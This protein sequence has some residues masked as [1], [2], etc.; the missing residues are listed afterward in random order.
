M[1]LLVVNQLS[2]QTNQETKELQNLKDTILHFDS[3]FWEAYNVCDLEQMATFFTEDL[4]FYHDKGGLTT[5]RASLIEVTKK[6]ICSSENW[7][8]RREVVEGSLKVYP[9]NNYGAI[10]S[11]EHVFY[12]NEEGKKERLDGLAK[13]THVWQYKDNAWKMSRVLSY[14]HGPATEKSLKKE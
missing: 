14:D 12:I 11:G 5:T 6:G 13:F 8:L 4:E 3:L 7:W 1:P 2:A 9:L 10:L